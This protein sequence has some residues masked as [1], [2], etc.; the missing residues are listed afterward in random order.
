VV[1]H[2]RVRRTLFEPSRRFAPLSTQDSA[3][4]ANPQLR[5]GRHPAVFCF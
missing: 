1:T 2:T 4:R 5:E 3:R